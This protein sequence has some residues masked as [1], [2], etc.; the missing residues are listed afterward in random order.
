MTNV[1]N[2]TTV[3]GL[4]DSVAQAQSAVQQLVDRGIDR[5]QISLVSR[6]SSG[7][8][9]TTDAR[10]DDDLRTTSAD[11]TTLGE[12][13]AGGALFGGLGGLL[14]GLCRSGG[15]ISDNSGRRRH[16]R[17]G[18]RRHRRLEAGRRS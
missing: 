11:G 12:N 18:R 13:V 8:S 2:T 6:N 10:T 7:A 5:N 3:V 1:Q 15:S 17:S 16:R 4:F 9:S 14:I